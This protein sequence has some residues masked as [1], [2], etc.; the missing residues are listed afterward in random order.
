[1]KIIQFLINQFATREE[2]ATQFVPIEPIINT[3]KRIGGTSGSTY[4][5]FIET[6]NI[7][8]V[9][10][11]KKTN[12]IVD[13]SI[14]YYHHKKFKVY[15]STNSILQHEALLKKLQ[16]TYKTE[17]DRFEINISTD[18]VESNSDSTK[19]DSTETEPD[20]T[21][22]DSTETEAESDSTETDSTE[23]ETDSTE[24]M[25]QN[26][27]L[28]ELT[29]DEKFSDIDDNIVE[30]E[31]RGE[32]HQ[33]KILFKA[34]DIE[35]FLGMG[36]LEDTIQDTRRAYVNNIHYVKLY[37]YTDKFHN[38]SLTRHCLAKEV[39]EEKELRLTAKPLY[40]TL[41]GLFK[42][43]FC[44]VSANQNIAK[45]RDWVINLAYVHQ[46]GTRE[47]RST[48]TNSLFKKCLNNISGI[49]CIRLGKV[50]DLRESMSISTELYP[51]IGF[52]N[53]HVFKVGR[54]ENIDKRF[55]QHCARTGYGKY[56]GQSGDKIILDWCI[57]IPK[58]LLVDAENDL[59]KYF[60]TNK[61]LFEF[62]D[63][64]KDHTE[65]IIVKSGLERKQ[66]R[67]KYLDLVKC[68]P[69]VANDVIKQLSDTR[70]EFDRT[71]ELTEAK[72]TNQLLE[73]ANK[74]NMLEAANKI[75]MLEANSKILLLSHKVELLE[76]TAKYTQ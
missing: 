10:Y 46:F 55:A 32:R 13:Q 60:K 44:S 43:V 1:M 39:K 51:A 26:F 65:L 75:N 72:H 56:L 5:N 42:V 58:T 15:I 76:L 52:D 31:V 30:I 63:G 69:G 27:E 71:L 40:L 73:A 7:D 17:L 48:L 11:N 38:I 3:Y 21:E 49:Y 18:S 4:Q 22:I 61:M 36:R 34:S 57:N 29:K 28:I 19:T 67:E 68:F 24:K 54:A 35:E 14:D 20:S 45:L 33:D 70:A 8:Y 25:F 41:G 50:K 2:N 59:H 9:M 47:E 53:A 37:Q 6:N 74:I 62:N 64:T 16:E 12:K 66:V 23:T